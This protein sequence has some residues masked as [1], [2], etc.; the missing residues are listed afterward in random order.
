MTDLKLQEVIMDEIRSMLDSQ[1]LKKMDGSVWK[2]FNIYRQDKPMKDDAEDDDQE[3]Y[4]IVMLDDEDLGADNKWKV[5]V[6]ILISICLYDEER[7]GNVVLAN[8][9]NQIFMHFQKKGIIGEMFE[10]ESEA[11][12]RFNQECYPNYYECDLITVWKLPEIHMETEDDL[13]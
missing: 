13:I 4:I 2:D 11:H 5:D 1:S 10:M 6:H 7:Q 9:M 3:D 12:K 8:L